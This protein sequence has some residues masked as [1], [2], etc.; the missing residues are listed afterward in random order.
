MTRILFDTCHRMHILCLM[1][2]RPATL[3][4]KIY[5]LPW[6]RQVLHAWFERLE[7]TQDS[8]LLEVGC[9][10]GQLTGFIANRG[11]NAVG[12]DNSA[13]MLKQA[14]SSTA[15]RARFEM[16]SA[17]NL[18]FENN[19]FDCVIA[20]SLLNII[21]QPEAAFS[22]M[23]RVCKPG[24]KVSVLVPQAAMT[25]Q[26]VAHL[27]SE[28]ELSG[29]SRAVL[30]SWHRHAPKMQKAKV[31]EYFSRAGLQHIESNTYLNGMVLTVTGTLAS[32]CG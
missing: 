24:G 27:A 12:V 16:A 20:A 30:A 1:L 8:D 18:P 7:C 21:S 28:L 29:F 5:A 31:I 10:S 19:Q 6:Y 15:N 9:A 11:I 17:V 22:E 13:N 3:F 26:A 25:D 23:L 4:R 32:S 14:K 2:F